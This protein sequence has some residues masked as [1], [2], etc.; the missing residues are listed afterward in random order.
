MREC[1][2]SFGC[3]EVSLCRQNARA[4]GDTITEDEG[5]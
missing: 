4:P 1:I 5:D 3:C 2:N